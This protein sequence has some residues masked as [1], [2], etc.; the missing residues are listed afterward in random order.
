MRSLETG[1]GLRGRP[2]EGAGDAA[3][4]GARACEI[5]TH[6]A[7]L[8]PELLRPVQ[9]NDIDRMAFQVEH[10]YVPG[11]SIA[12]LGGGL[13]L[14]APTCAALG[15]QAYLV[16]DFGDEVN[17]V[18]RIEDMV[19]HRETGVRVVTTE[20]NRWGEHFADESLD[21]VTSFDSIEHWHHSPRRAFREA[22]RVL[23]PGGMLFIGAPNAVNLRKRVSV[24]LGRTNWS[25]FEQWYYPDRFRG[26]VREPVLADL[27]RMIDDLGFEPKAVWGRNWAGHWGGRLRRA[28][29]GAIDLPLR[30][31]PTLCSDLYVMAS[32]P[33][34]PAS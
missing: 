5:M 31:R 16:D 9:R 4:V 32:K 26:H 14:F 12:D 18:Y 20:M 33:V 21:V 15:M 30:L 7:E 19:A 6:W 23:R 1:I 10:A 8:A 29:A 3:D 13:G 24:L 25:T 27:L 28:V 34:K 17:E 11:G 22:Y 2:R